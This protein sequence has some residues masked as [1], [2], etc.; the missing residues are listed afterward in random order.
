M[1][2]AELV[3]TQ[4][5][6]RTSHKGA[7]IEILETVAVPFDQ[8]IRTFTSARIEIVGINYPHCIKRIAPT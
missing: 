2:L 5:I 1:I 4:V 3:S 6:Y 8:I 7:R